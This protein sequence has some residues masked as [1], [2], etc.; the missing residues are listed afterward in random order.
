MTMTAKLSPRCT[1]TL[2]KKLREKFA[3]TGEAA[4]VLEDTSQGILVRPA[5]VFPIEHYS[6]M[7]IADFEAE[8]NQAIAKFFPVQGSKRKAR[9]RQVLAVETGNRA[10]RAHP[11]SSPN[12][13]RRP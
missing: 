5:A 13:T 6:D 8:N 9:G 4:V 2:P 1:L 12:N 10:G 11:N 3:L 7:R